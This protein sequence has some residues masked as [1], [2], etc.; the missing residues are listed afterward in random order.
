MPTSINL[1]K[2]PSLP[3]T[4]RIKKA[5]VLIVDDRPEGLFSIE[6]VLQSADRTFEIKKAASGFEA[7]DLVKE[8]EFAVI[9][10][11]VQMPGMDGFQTAERIRQVS[12]HVPIIFITAISHDDT[13]VYRG[14]DS[15]AVDYL[16]K[17]LNAAVLRSKVAVFID[18]FNKT[19]ILEERSF[20]LRDSERRDHEFE[21]RKLADAI[22][23]LVFR[24]GNDGEADYF[25]SG[26][27]ALTGLS[28][29]ESR[30]HGWRNAV[31]S[32]DLNVLLEHWA[33]A[34]EK[35]APFDAEVRV[36]S[37]SGLSERWQLIRG[38]PELERDGQLVGW[39]FTGTDIHDRKEALIQLER[40][41]IELQESNRDLEQFAYIASH[42]LQEPLRKISNY[43]DLLQL[44][45]E[46]KLSERAQR[47]M[48]PILTGARRMQQLITDLLNYSRVAKGEV[49]SQI[50]FNLARVVATAL[51]TI[52]AHEK[53]D[54]AVEPLP[55]LKGDPLQIQQLFQNLVSNAIKFR[56]EERPRIVVGSAA[57]GSTRTFF[58]RDNGIGIPPEYHERIFVIFKRLHNQDR[59]PGTGIGL[60]I[61]KK[62]VEWHGGRIWVESEPGKGSTFYFTL[63][64]ID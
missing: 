54:V 22:P 46:G 4:F 52:G 23:H 51:E 37:K 58:V 13:H 32:S 40:Q 10:L 6:A 43:V 35:I 53:A 47:C 44:Y 55:W 34:K 45:T 48:T 29:I 7:L 61:C 3:E 8:T 17:P 41:T 50:D 26:W 39:L 28:E 60:A 15:G 25:N 57:S 16:F 19:Q 18:L 12:P 30:G 42:D 21:Y 27:L 1:N 56:G 36:R 63:A 9:L 14:Y 62:V 64:P 59:Y 49:G 31:S 33:V 38:V 24:T 5:A 20:R 2:R 11:D